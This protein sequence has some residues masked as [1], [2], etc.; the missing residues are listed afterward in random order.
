[1]SSSAGKTFW[2]KNFGSDVPAEPK[3]PGT[4]R[5]GGTATVTIQA[6]K[7]QIKLK[8]EIELR[9]TV[10]DKNKSPISKA[11]VDLAVS[12]SATGSR[13]VPKSVATDDAG[14]ATA[15]FI[16][17]SRDGGAV[18]TAQSRGSTVTFAIQVGKGE[19][20]PGPTKV[21]QT[22]QEQGYKVN[23]VGKAT[24]SPNSVYVDMAV[25]GTVTDKSGELDPETVTQ[26]TDGWVALM[27]AYPQATLLTVITRTTDFAVHWPAKPQDVKGYLDNKVSADDF[28][29][30]VMSTMKIY[31][32]KTGKVVSAKDFVSKNFK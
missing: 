16:A 1:M 23:A 29:G 7:T 8:G 9:I 6:D 30:R 13:V 31:D 28:W 4:T 18:V 26:V 24:D 12:G 11:N 21:R 20:D 14:L 27:D 19:S 15:T 22:L 2:R 10:L 5:A 17:G 25:A 3:F 32:I